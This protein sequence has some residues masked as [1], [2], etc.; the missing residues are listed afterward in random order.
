MENKDNLLKICDL[1]FSITEFDIGLFDQNLNSLCFLTN[2]AYP[3]S[4]FQFFTNFESQLLFHP[5]NRSES[6]CFWQSVPEL[7]FLYLII[8]IQI[9]TSEH[10]YAIIGPVL[11]LSYSDIL[12][13]TILKKANLPLSELE[14]FSSLYKSLP[15][16][17]TKTKNLFLTCYHLLTTVKLVEL[18]TALPKEDF[19]SEVSAFSPISSQPSYSKADIQLNY[20]KERLWRSAISKGDVKNAKKLFNEMTSSDYLYCTPDDS[21]QT[22]KHILFILRLSTFEFFFLSNKNILHF[23]F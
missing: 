18:P 2:R 14:N 21:L 10:Y 23:S 17:Q 11:S 13:K 4:M 3:D 9:T 8:R 12:I 5:E 20:E 19:V 7:E 1:L 15:L 16:Y 22:R 6:C